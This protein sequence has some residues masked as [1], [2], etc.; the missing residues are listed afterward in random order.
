[1]RET[2]LERDWTKG[3]IFGNLVSLSWPMMVHEGFYLMSQL[4]DMIWV[5]KLGV[6]HIA[7]VGIASIIAMVIRS[8]AMGL[9]TGTIALVARFVGA[10][11]V[12]G[13]NRIASQAFVISFV[14]GAAVTVIAVPFAKPIL[15]LFGL[16]AS[17]AAEGTAYMRML[18]V[19]TVA[20][21][22]WGVGQSIMKASGDPVTP[23]RVSIFVRCVHIALDPFFIFGWWVFPRMGVSGAALSNIVAQT[24]GASILLWFFFNGRTRLRLTL[25]NFGVDLS[26]IWRIVKIGIPAGV[27]SMQRSFGNLM[28]TWFMVPFGTFAVA[29]HSLYQK[30][31]QVVFMPSWVLGMGSGV[32]V[33]QNLGARQPGRA[34][35]TGW[36]ATGL[37]EGVMFICSVAILLWAESIIC[38]FNP[39]PGLVEIASVF[40]RIATAGFL[41]VGFVG[42][43]QRSIAGAGDTLPP[44]LISLVMIWAVQLPLAYFL[45]RVTNLGMYGVGWAIVTGVVMGAVALIIYF[46]LGRWK[47][48]KV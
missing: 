9:T 5:G 12:R 15:G 17:V 25:S 33:G 7:G 35:R 43:L 16:E 46:R 13:A 36:A 39:E 48:K 1:M 41:V 3:S 18:L 4:V 2:A 23:M 20:M 19:G 31:R 37:A 11:D 10:G 47:H 14:Y 21:S 32:L 28:L 45:P 6:A 29:A 40:L 34:E 44:M 22:F 24:L 8:A 30:I 26:I 42:V 38:L 27:M